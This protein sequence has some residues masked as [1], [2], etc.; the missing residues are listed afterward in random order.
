MEWAHIPIAL[1]V[2][3]VHSIIERLINRRE[4]LMTLIRELEALEVPPKQHQVQALHE[5]M[6]KHASDHLVH[7]DPDSR[8]RELTSKTKVESTEGS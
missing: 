5:H 7:Q 6:R 4:Q 8:H 1:P 2:D 3:E